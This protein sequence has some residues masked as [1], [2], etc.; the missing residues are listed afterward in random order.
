MVPESHV[1]RDTY[2]DHAGPCRTPVL[3]HLHLEMVLM[4]VFDLQIYIF[5]LKKYSTMRWY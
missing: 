1:N 3:D 2:I 5:D 4:D